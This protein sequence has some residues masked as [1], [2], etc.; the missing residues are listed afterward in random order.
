SSNTP[1]CLC[2]CRIVSLATLASIVRLNDP[3]VRRLVDY[4]SRATY[5]PLDQTPL[6]EQLVSGEKALPLSVAQDQ[7]L[8]AS[9]DPSIS[10]TVSAPQPTAMASTA[11]VALP[12][13]A[14]SEVFESLTPAWPHCRAAAPRS[15]RRTPV[16]PWAAGVAGTLVLVVTVVLF[17]ETWHGPHQALGGPAL[18][19]N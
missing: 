16:W 10:R 3:E 9:A 1:T 4:L 11:G 8:T 7:V 17:L 15:R 14:A 19:H 2:S 6:L 12:V 18:T 13:Q 5:K